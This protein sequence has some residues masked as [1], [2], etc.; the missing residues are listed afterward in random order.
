MSCFD[1]R[2]QANELIHARWAMLGAAG[3]IIPEAFNKFGANCGPEAVWFKVL[4][5]PPFYHWNRTSI[6]LGREYSSLLITSL[7]FLIHLIHIYISSMS[8][9]FLSSCNGTNQFYYLSLKALAF[10]L[11]GY[12]EI[13]L[14]LYSI[15]DKRN[16]IQHFLLSISEHSLYSPVFR[17]SFF[18]ENKN[19]L[20]DINVPYKMRIL[21]NE[22]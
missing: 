21:K 13:S 19:K 9:T 10:I 17:F 6:N 14:S 5:Y 4:F 20:V 15:L 1:C 7:Y 2:Y 8:Y 16:V 12:I 18:L 11:M 22:E 3:F